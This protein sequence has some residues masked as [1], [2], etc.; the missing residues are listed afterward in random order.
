MYKVTKYQEVQLLF[1]HLKSIVCDEYD[2]CI[3]SEKNSA[4]VHNYL[5][6]I[7]IGVI[8]D[9]YDILKYISSTRLVKTCQI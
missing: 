4:M 9:S 6:D 8:Q 7:L 2:G 5:Q 3:L 1:T